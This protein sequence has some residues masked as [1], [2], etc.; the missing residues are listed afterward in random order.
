MQ[1]R[2]INIILFNYLILLFLTIA[3]AL[4]Q[5]NKYETLIKKPTSHLKLMLI[6]LNKTIEEQYR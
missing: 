3:V 4:S 1:Q 6:C 2:K 5:Q